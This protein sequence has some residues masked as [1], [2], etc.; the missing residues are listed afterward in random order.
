ML[1]YTIKRNTI[2]HSASSLIHKTYGLVAIGLLMSTFG[3]YFSL[4]FHFGIIGTL[5]LLLLSIGLMYGASK[6]KYNEWG[7]PLFFGFTFIIG[8]MTGPLINSYLSL[9]NGDSIVF[10]A[11]ITTFLATG[12]LTFYAMKSGRNFNQIAGFLFVGMIMILVGGIINMFTKSSLFDLVLASMGALIFS[13]YILYDTSRLIRGEVNSP[14]DGAI[15]LFL[16]IFN[17]FTSIL[18]IFGGPNR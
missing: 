18:R 15:S 6:N 14:V 17:L 10:K 8:F 3:S 11:F 16:G 2:S 13:G 7:L 1:E 12:G 9:P 5:C 4:G